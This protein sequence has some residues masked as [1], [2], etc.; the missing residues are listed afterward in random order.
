MWVLASAHQL[1]A[2]LGDLFILLCFMVSMFETRIHK[3]ES[4]FLGEVSTTSDMQMT[5][6]LWQKVKILWGYSFLKAVK[7]W[8]LI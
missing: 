8:P 3:L 6:P 7:E 5:P 4:R 2:S 1:D